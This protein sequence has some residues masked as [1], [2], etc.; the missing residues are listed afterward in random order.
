MN[1]KLF[2]ISAMLVG[3]FLVVHFEG[4]MASSGS[5]SSLWAQKINQ[6][7]TTLSLG[8]GPG[9][10]WY[11]L[12]QGGPGRGAQRY[13]QGRSQEWFFEPQNGGSSQLYQDMSAWAT[14]QPFQAPVKVV[15]L[16]PAQVAAAKKAQEVAEAAAQMVAKIAA[17]QAQ[18]KAAAR[19][20]LFSLPPIT[21]PVCMNAYA[22]EAGDFS[23]A[24][25]TNDVNGVVGY[26]NICVNGP[27]DGRRVQDPS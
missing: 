10:V 1:K 21:S 17:E 6:E 16:T 5:D 8:A 18:A 24:Y 3:A 12:Q 20:K 9:N 22:N 2:S 13:L 19:A 23:N 4:A 26:L 7:I 11:A 15:P 27:Y 14:N 25:V